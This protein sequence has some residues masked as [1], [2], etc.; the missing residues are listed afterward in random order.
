MSQR[1][2]R[3]IMSYK[4]NRDGIEG[5]GAKRGLQFDLRVTNHTRNSDIKIMITQSSA[6]T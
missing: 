5:H 4:E 2:L 6:E 1:V 3:D